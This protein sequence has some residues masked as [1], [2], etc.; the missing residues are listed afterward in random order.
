MQCYSGGVQ[1]ASSRSE[2]YPFKYSESIRPQIC[3][4]NNDRYIDICT[5]NLNV[6]RAAELFCS[7]FGYSISSVSSDE[8]LRGADTNR[9][10]ATN[11]SCPYDY[12]GSSCNFNVSSTC[13]GTPLVVECRR[14]CNEGYARIV[15]GVPTQLSNGS[16]AYTGILEV[17][18]NGQWASICYN[19]SNLT[20]NTQDAI[21]RACS[22]LGYTGYNNITKICHW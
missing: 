10:Y 4:A 9:L 2:S 22:G 21:R 16:Q 19:G 15:N 12:V 6:S 20:Q 18:N 1:R 14:A 3:D 7:Y 17:C 8:S 11:F 13:S 5:D